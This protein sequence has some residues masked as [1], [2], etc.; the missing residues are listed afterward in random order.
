MFN[1]CTQLLLCSF[2]G[3][4]DAAALLQLQHP[5]NACVKAGAELLFT[6]IYR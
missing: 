6:I 1:F 3:L 2:L 5:A 4:L